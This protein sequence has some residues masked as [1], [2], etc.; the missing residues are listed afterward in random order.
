MTEPRRPKQ[1][2]KITYPNGKIY[3]G[4]DLRGDLHYCGSPS[5]VQ[6][7]AD[8]LGIEPAEV[9]HYPLASERVVTK[10]GNR[11]RI[12]LPHL[13]LV[14]RKDILWESTTATDTE[15]R[16]LEK[17]WIRSTGANNPKIGYNKVPRYAH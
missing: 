13:N 4:S 17:E 8:D 14:V 11:I 6:Q 15:V 1:I 7:I 16:A 5:A 3:V 9:P 10:R 12:K 2:Y